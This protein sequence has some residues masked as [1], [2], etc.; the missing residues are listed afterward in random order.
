MR[1]VMLRIIHRYHDS[2]KE[3]FSGIVFYLLNPAAKLLLFFEICK[4]R[5]KKNVFLVTKVGSLW[6][7]E[8]FCTIKTVFDSFFTFFFFMTRGHKANKSI[9]K[10]HK[11]KKVCTFLAFYFFIASNK[12]SLCGIKWCKSYRNLHFICKRLAY[13][14]KKY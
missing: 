7:K 2:I 12:A 10:W 11:L 9:A 5:G 13:V 6:I 1:R 3:T 14:R 8:V 4:R